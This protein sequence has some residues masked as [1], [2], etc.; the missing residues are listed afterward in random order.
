MEL[1][2]GS[3]TKKTTKVDDYDFKGKRVLLAEDNEMN[4]EIAIDLLEMV[5][6]QVEAANDGKQ[7]VDMFNNSEVGYYDLILMDIQMPRLDGYQA[8][9]T[10]RKLDKEDASSIPIVA[11]TAN[12]FNEDIQ[13]AL[14]AGMNDHVAKPIDTK[15]LYETI[16]KYVIKD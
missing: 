15:V 5:N 4:Q 9:R 7:A 2:G 1:S 11:M 3:L 14:V 6:L 12:A 8:S 10:I 13:N 16:A